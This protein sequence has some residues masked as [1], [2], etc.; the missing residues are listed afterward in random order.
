M[1]LDVTI[2][3][4][5]GG[6]VCRWSISE[7]YRAPADELGLGGVLWPKDE[8]ENNRPADEIGAKIMVSIGGFGIE[9]GWMFDEYDTNH[10][11]IG[12]FIRTLCHI[13]GEC[14]VWRNCKVNFTY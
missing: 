11:C 2:I 10:V 9:W 1:S 5:D 4:E 3:T 12:Y 14:V 6:E 13:A 7:H 8:S